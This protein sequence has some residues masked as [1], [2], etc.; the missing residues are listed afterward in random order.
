MSRFFSAMISA[1][2]SMGRPAPLKMRPSMSSETDSCKDLP[3]KRALEPSVPT[4]RVASNIW[5][6]AMSSRAS[7]TLPSLFSPVAVVTSTNSSYLMPSTPSTMRSGPAIEVI[8]LY[9]FCMIFS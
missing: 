6:K 9:S 2:P 4:P 1:P 7:R 8:D 3:K 5:T